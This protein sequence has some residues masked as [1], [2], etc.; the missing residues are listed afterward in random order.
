MMPNRVRAVLRAAF[1]EAAAM[2]GIGAVFLG[3][4][5]RPGGGA[6]GL[7]NLTRDL[8]GHPAGSTVTAEGLR[9]EGLL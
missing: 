7:W 8:P 1:D 6:I 5:P 2:R 4:Q 3:T 9:R